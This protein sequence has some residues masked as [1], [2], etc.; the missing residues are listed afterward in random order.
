[1]EHFKACLIG[2]KATTETTNI[3]NSILILK[4]AKIY[5]YRRLQETIHELSLN[6]IYLPLY[7]SFLNPIENLFSV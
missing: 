6:I 7:S 5:H 3:S 4:N 2:L 1:M